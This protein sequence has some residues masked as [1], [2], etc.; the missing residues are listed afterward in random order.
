[1]SHDE[2]VRRLEQLPRWYYATATPQLRPL[3]YSVYFWGRMNDGSSESLT[4]FWKSSSG[5]SSHREQSISKTSP[6]SFAI[7]NSQENWKSRTPRW[8]PQAT[9]CNATLHIKTYYSS[10]LRVSKG[11]STE[12]IEELCVIIGLAFNQVVAV[13]LGTPFPLVSQAY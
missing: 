7:T 12:E 11:G 2:A 1:V 3:L 8:I 6:S 10:C 9:V 5:S 13:E 4:G